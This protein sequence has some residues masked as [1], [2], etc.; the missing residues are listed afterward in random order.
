MM[1]SIVKLMG[2][3]GRFWKAK[4]IC[5]F[6]GKSFLEEYTHLEEDNGVVKSHQCR[7]QSV[8]PRVG[9]IFATLLLPKG[10]H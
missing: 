7:Q 5:N 9:H 8:L 6:W 10:S 4:V 3:S 2:L 1:L